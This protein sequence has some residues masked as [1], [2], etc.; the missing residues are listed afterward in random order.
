MCYLLKY[1]LSEKTMVQIS[2][3]CW[4][5]HVTFTILPPKSHKRTSD[6]RHLATFVNNSKMQYSKTAYFNS[7]TS[8][9][10]LWTL[11]V[12]KYFHWHWTVK[13]EYEQFQVRTR[14][15]CTLHSHQAMLLPAKIILQ[16]S[17][18]WNKL[19][20]RNILAKLFRRRILPSAH[21]NTLPES[22]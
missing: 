18:Q 12:F 16:N 13:T 2:T 5:S 11:S 7:R 14:H 3:G 19:W 1:N 20:W 22:I 6:R 10:L 4:K 21:A 15:T 9:V 17:V 8:K